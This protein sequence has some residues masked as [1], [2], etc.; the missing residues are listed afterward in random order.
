M[1][2]DDLAHKLREEGV[3][4]VIEPTLAGARPAGVVERR[5]CLR[6]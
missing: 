3:R 4:C 6:L 5:P 1:W 2:V